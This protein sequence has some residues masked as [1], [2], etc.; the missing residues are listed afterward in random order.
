MAEQNWNIDFTRVKILGFWA[1]LRG[2]GVAWMMR[3]ESTCQISPL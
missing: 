3:F 1:H 2:V